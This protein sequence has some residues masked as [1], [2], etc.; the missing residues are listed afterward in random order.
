MID[1]R[2]MLVPH[3]FSFGVAQFH[4]EGLILVERTATANG[5]IHHRLAVADIGGADKSLP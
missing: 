2:T 3:Q 4:L 5:D 1:L